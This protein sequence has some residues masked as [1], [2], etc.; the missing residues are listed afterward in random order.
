M[1]VLE[2]DS[3]LNL[4]VKRIV[5]GVNPEKIFLFGS[6]IWGNPTEDSDFDLLIVADIPTSSKSKSKFMERIERR[7]EVRNL[8]LDI[9]ENIPID[10]FVYTPEEFKHL[11]K[12]NTSFIREILEKGEILYEKEDQRVD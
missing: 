9:N 11:K 4:I 5:A 1:K 8:I 6:Y 12:L 2:K 7:I 10:L 3:L